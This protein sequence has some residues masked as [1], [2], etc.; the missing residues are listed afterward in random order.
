MWRP[1]GVRPCK[2]P[3]T[4]TH[5]GALTMGRKHSEQQLRKLQKNRASAAHASIMNQPQSALSEVELK[6]MID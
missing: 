5:N 2:I 4:A 1:E 3:V 6:L